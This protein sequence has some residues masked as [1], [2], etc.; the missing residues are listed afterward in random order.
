MRT[1][2]CMVIILT[3]A[4]IVAAASR[5]SFRSSSSSS[6]AA[7][8]SPT[9]EHILTDTE[10]MVAY[11]FVNGIDSSLPVK[12]I[13]ACARVDASKPYSENRIVM[14]ACAQSITPLLR[15]MRYVSKQAA[16]LEV[17]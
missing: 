17:E 15:S 12:P 13:P 4:T 9:Y 7:L 5:E 16:Q 3:L 8:K 10:K 2:L 1:V 11:D 14:N 6:K